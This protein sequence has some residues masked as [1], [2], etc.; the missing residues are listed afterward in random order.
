[1]LQGTADAVRQYLWLFEEAQV[2][3]FV[4]LAG[5][6]L[7][8]MDYQKFVQVHRETGADITIAALPMDEVRAT[9]FG[10][11]KIDDKGRI[12]EFAEKPSG[13]E[14]RAMQVC[15]SCGSLKDMNFLFSMLD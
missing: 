15:G 3:E 12:I 6:H 14:L 13:D 4:V 11:M 5:D 9:A 8:R 2:L 10:L 7:S 1:V